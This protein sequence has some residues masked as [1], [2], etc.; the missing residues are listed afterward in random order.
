M[1]ITAGITGSVLT[2]LQYCSLNLHYKNPHDES[3]DTN[4]K[5]IKRDCCV[6][7]LTLTRTYRIVP[8]PRTITGTTVY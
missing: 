5:K 6:H 8:E 7:S 3:H 2:G 4:I 1:L